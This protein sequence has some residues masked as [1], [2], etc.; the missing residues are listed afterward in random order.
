MEVTEDFH[1]LFVEG[2]DHEKIKEAQ[3][4]SSPSPFTF[5]VGLEMASCMIM[6]QG[7]STSTHHYPQPIIGHIE[8]IGRLRMPSESDERDENDHNDKL[9][10]RVNKKSKSNQKQKQKKQGKGKPRN[11]KRKT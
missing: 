10:S 5:S 8:M 3:D 11:H 7:L 4:R 6:A 1:D 2:D 9:S